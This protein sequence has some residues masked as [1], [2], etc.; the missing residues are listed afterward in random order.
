M[1]VFA[2]GCGNSK[3]EEA[4]KEALMEKEIHA[5]DSISN[6]LDN[7]TEGIEQTTEELDQLLNDL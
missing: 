4:A 7:T 3:A 5:L 6:V 2:M 1:A